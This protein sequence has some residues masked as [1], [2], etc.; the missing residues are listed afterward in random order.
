MADS[1]LSALNELTTLSAT[2]QLYVTPLV[3]G[4]RRDR[5][6]T[7]AN[8]ASGVKLLAGSAGAVGAVGVA[9]GTTTVGLFSGGSGATEYL[10]LAAN[11]VEVLRSTASQATMSVPLTVTRSGV[12]ECVLVGGTLTGADLFSHAFTDSTEFS[13]TSTG[14]YATIDSVPE[15][16]GTIGYNHFYSFQS[17]HIY[18]GSGVLDTMTSFVAYPTVSGPVTNLYGLHI[19]NAV[20]AGAVGSQVGIWID[21]LTRGTSK[22]AIFSAGSAPSYFGGMLQ[23]GAHIQA[24]KARFTDF[25]DYGAVVTTDAD[26]YTL[27]NPNLTIINGTLTMANATTSK[28]LASVTGLELASTSGDVTLS[29]GGNVKFGTHSAVAAETVSGYITIKDAGGTL[30]KLA[31]IS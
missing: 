18:S 22:Y 28:V 25:S 19:Y 10:A 26:G 20:G 24:T 16:V 13:S 2:D 6:M 5:R 11:G 27:T 9:V 14:A 4:T 31:V 7:A 21:D 23:L 30:R 29:A 17:R 1:K 8:L 15:M 3:T 12:V